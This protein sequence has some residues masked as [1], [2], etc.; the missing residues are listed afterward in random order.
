MRYQE[1]RRVLCLKCNTV[2]SAPKK[3]DGDFKCVNS[4]CGNVA[5]IA[6]DMC[7]TINGYVIGLN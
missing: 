5:S 4:S 2:Q 7:S 6:E 3:L 1:D